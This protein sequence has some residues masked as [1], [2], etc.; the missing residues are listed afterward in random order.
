MH[1]T[2]SGAAQVLFEITI[3]KV[4]DLPETRGPLRIE[5]KRSSEKG[6]V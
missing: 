6:K 3:H 1:L 4:S 5:W 2:K